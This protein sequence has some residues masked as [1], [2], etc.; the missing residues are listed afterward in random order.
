MAAAREAL[1]P[2][3]Q[4]LLDPLMTAPSKLPDTEPVVVVDL[5]RSTII[6]YS[7]EGVFPKECK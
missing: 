7:L 1:E 3:V 5:A 2:V 4:R 6:R